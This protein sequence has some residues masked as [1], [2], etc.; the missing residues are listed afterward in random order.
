MQYKQ[1]KV[2]QSKEDGKDF[3][4]CLSGCIYFCVCMGGEC[5]IK[6]VTFEQIDEELSRAL[7]GGEAE[8]G[9][10]PWRGVCLESVRCRVGGERG[11][12][13]AMTCGAV[14]APYASALPWSPGGWK[15]TGFW[16]ERCS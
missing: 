10:R 14:D 8:L 4:I 5:I 1:E 3:C 12:G 15:T 7:S 16:V 6:E 13:R 9:A 11:G 2:R